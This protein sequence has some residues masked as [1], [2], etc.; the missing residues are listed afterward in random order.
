VPDA[1]VR[2]GAILRR[3]VILALRQPLGSITRWFS[4][5]IGIAGFY[6]VAR[7]VDPHRALSIDGHRE[8]Y[9]AYVSVNL[10]F[11]VLQTS[12]LQAF[13]Q[14]IR[15][16]QLVGTL[17]PIFASPA[18]TGLIV[19][20]CGVWPLAISLAQVMLCL[21]GASLFMGLD[22]HAT[23][24]ASLLTFVA[25]STLT[26]GAIGIL[27]AA[28]VIAFK[29]VPPSNY[30]VGGAAS[31]LSGTLFPTHLFPPVLQLVSWCLP[32]THALRG[33]RGAIAG[34]GIAATAGDALWLAVTAA[35]LFPA[36]FILLHFA[37][38]RAKC[39]GTLAQ[40]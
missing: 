17:E 6:F 19:A 34:D 7:F 14:S 24:L 10:S 16:D 25:L 20:S 28:G 36:S 38:E 29:Q 9:F 39:D 32:L 40:Y 1:F 11:M 21:A 8:G 3:D 26:M 27:S 23:D 31:L 33:L 15:Y 5:I 22:L 30:L 13:S 18:P 4:P 35:L 37:V 2:I 12:A